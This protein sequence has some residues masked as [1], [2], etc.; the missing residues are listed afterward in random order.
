MNDTNR[1]IYIENLEGQLKQLNVQ[2][3]DSIENK[4]RETNRQHFADIEATT[5][6][7]IKALAKRIELLEVKLQKRKEAEH[8][9]L[10]HAQETEQ[11]R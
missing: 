5:T 4:S 8:G 6:L 11:D 7:L 2:M 9:T 1:R 10:L 3:R